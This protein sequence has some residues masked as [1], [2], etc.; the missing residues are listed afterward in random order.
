MGEDK[1]RS[2]FE[3]RKDRLNI[4]IIYLKIREIKQKAK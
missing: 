3:N 2:D 4:K 1:L